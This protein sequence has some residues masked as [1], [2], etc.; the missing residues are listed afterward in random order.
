MKLIS[1]LFIAFVAGLGP[2]AAGAAEPASVRLDLATALSELERNNPG[3]SAAHA[4]TR[5]AEA[6]ISEARS[7]LLPTL[8]ATGGYVRNS[9]EVEVRLGSLLGQIPG[10][11]DVP[12]LVIQPLDAWTASGTLTV[13]LVVPTAWY[14]VDAAKAG[15]RAAQASSELGRR[16]LRTALATLAYGAAAMRAVV[17]A[18]ERA[19]EL[20]REQVASAE[21]RVA[22]GTA[23]PLDVLRAKAEQ[24]NRESDLARARADSARADLALGILLGRETPVV[25]TVPD[26]E[27]QRPNPAPASPPTPGRRPE[28]DAL[29]AKAEA[30]RE[31]IGSAQARH[32]PTLHAM[33]SLFA[34]DEPYPTGDRTGWRVGVELR[35]PLYDGG[36][37]YGRRHEAEAELEAAQAELSQRRLAI[38]QETSD[39]RREVEVARERKRLA[40]AQQE[41]AQSAAESAKRSYDAGVGTTLDVLDANDKL[42]RADVALA[43]AKALVAKSLIALERA[44]GTGP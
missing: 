5:A 12:N 19:V 2:R 11:P 8:V 22:A 39:A 26:L 10:A 6:R 13:P 38:H 33:G 37:R 21:R 35:I 15:H 9:A 41:L 43:Q 20:A 31:Q 16:E 36:Y 23:A 4:R 7:A 25:I 44:L 27:A 42:Y 17:G 14:D 1:V 29:Q 24:V 40:F 18:S 34:S 30:A 32:L 28:L 3:L